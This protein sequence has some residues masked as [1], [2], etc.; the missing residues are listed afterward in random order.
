MM[1]RLHA[2]DPSP[3]GEHETVLHSRLLR[4]S[5]IQSAASDTASGFVSTVAASLDTATVTTKGL[6]DFCSLSPE[7]SAQFSALL[8]LIFNEVQV[9]YLLNREDVL[10]ESLWRS[11]VSIASFYLAAPGGRDAWRMWRELRDRDLVQYV[12]QELLAERVES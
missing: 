2:V 1:A 10:P 8:F 11:K 5:A 7:D 12:E 9:A 4:A 6:R 3:L